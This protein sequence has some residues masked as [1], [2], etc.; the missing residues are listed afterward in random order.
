[1]SFIEKI[2]KKSSKFDLIKS[3]QEK[4]DRAVY[5]SNIINNT[6]DEKEFYLSLNEITRILYELTKYENEISFKNPPSDDLKRLVENRNKTIELF[7]QRKSKK[8]FDIESFARECNSILEEKDNLDFDNMSGYDFENFCA[9]LLKTNGFESAEVTPGSKDQGIDIIAFKDGVKYGIQCKCYASDIGNKS[10]QEAYS[11]A[12]FYDCHVPVVLTNRYF[13]ISA[14]EL[15][16][17]NGVLLWD[18]DKLK[19]LIND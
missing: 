10:V 7:E 9:K 15:A 11:G 12:R 4:I 8:R 1:M 13:T 16:K 19:K 18:R 14:K 3:V 5:L 2:F 17:K 6:T